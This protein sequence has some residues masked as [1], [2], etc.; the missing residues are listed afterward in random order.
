MSRTDRL[1][2]V[3]TL[4][5]RAYDELLIR[6][7][8]LVE[9]NDGVHPSCTCYPGDDCPAHRTHA[10]LVDIWALLGDE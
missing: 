2:V 7:Y 3:E 10:V 4:L 6:Y 5:R 1:P 8:E 9:D